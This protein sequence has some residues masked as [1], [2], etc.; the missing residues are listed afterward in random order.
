[1]RRTIPCIG[2]ST[3]LSI[4]LAPLAVVAL[5]AL[6]NPPSSSLFV[7]LSGRYLPHTRSWGFVGVVV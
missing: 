5:V 2:R 4:P 7:R 3:G 1:M 6:Q